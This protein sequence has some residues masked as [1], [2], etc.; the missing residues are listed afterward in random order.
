MRAVATARFPSG[1][2]AGIAGTGRQRLPPSLPTSSKRERMARAAAWFASPLTDPRD[3]AGDVN[4]IF[5][6][7]PYSAKVP[8]AFDGV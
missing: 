1:R 5:E 4:G 3:A 2:A 6:R 7:T 8:E